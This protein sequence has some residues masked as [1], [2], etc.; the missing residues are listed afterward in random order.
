MESGLEHVPDSLTALDVLL[1]T[2][3]ALPQAISRLTA[4]RSLALTESWTEGGFEHLPP[5]IISLA[6]CLDGDAETT[7]VP[8]QLAQL[9]SLLTLSL[10]SCK[11]APLCGLGSL[12]PPGL[13]ALDF[14]CQQDLHATGAR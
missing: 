2:P 7:P 8:A 14:E 9:P 3:Y 11:H 13:L 6:L 12:G 10:S 4:L 5:T 1:A